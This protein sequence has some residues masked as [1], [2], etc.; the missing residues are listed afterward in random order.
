[1]RNGKRNAEKK[2]KMAKEMKK[3]GQAARRKGK[4]EI[5]CSLV[6]QH[7]CLWWKGGRGEGTVFTDLFLIL[8]PHSLLLTTFLLLS[9][10]FV[11]DVSCLI[12][13][14]ASVIVSYLVLFAFCHRLS[15]I[16]LRVL[17]GQHS[18]VCCLVILQHAVIHFLLPLSFFLS[19]SFSPSP[20]PDPFYYY[21]TLP[22]HTPGTSCPLHPV[23]MG[24]GGASL[25]VSFNL[26]I[27][28]SV[29]KLS[30]LPT[31]VG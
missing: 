11:P 1:M 12:S 6:W 10:L 26:H 4:T 29:A 20:A 5:C 13:P 18:W 30:G 15:V 14:P 31:V 7:H 23:H 8:S 24:R 19:L 9:L 17:F 27:P 16:F 3:G 28:F 2:R 22:L 21:W 25:P